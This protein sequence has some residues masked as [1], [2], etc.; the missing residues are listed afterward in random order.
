MNYYNNSNKNNATT[1]GLS[2]TPLYK[3]WK[4]MMYKVE[5]SNAEIDP[6]WACLESFM[7]DMDKAVLEAKSVVMT[8]IDPN[9]PYNK[10]NCAFIYKD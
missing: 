4:R 2:K 6:E 9:G 1:H 3:V 10:T 7:N 5:Q 8:R